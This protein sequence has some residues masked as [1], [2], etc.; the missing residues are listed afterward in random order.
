MTEAERRE[1]QRTR[2]RLDQLVDEVDLLIDQIRAEI[3]RE[4]AEREEQQQ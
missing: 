4:R 3:D 1:S 2:G